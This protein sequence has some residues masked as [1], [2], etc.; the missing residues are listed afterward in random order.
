MSQ[1]A[2][3]DPRSRRL[4]GALVAG[5]TVAT[6]EALPDFID[7]RGRRVAARFVLLGGAVP[8]LVAFAPRRALKFGG[9]DD[10][11]HD[12]YREPAERAS[13]LPDPQLAPPAAAGTPAGAPHLQA[14]ERRGKDAIVRRLA[15]RGMTRPRAT[16]GL[17]F[18]VLAAVTTYLDE[19][20]RP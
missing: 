19:T 20:K 14:G 4:A 6:W 13:A 18:G 15:D 8:M 12:P 7:H 17:A 9:A 3:P 16:L 5:V 1:N 11:E 10:T 2:A